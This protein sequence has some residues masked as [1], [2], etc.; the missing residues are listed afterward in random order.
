MRLINRFLTVQAVLVVSED[1]K[2][3]ALRMKIAAQLA[4]DHPWLTLDGDRVTAV[5]FAAYA[6]AV[7][8]QK[9]P[10]AFDA[11][12][13]SSGENQLFGSASEDKRHFTAYSQAHSS[14]AGAGMADDAAIKQ[15]NPLHYI[16]DKT[17]PQHW[18][19]PRW[20]RRPRHLARHR[21]H[22]RK[23]TGR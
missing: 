22:P 10:P 15:M 14:V 20:H 13:L 3:A 16:S 6:K 11:L 17:A 2:F 21:R 7:G 9:T 12:D 19:H 8:R 4:A 23:Q 1:A 5:D 18:R